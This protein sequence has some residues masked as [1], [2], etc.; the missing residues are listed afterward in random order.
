MAELYKTERGNKHTKWQIDHDK[1]PKQWLHPADRT[2]TIDTDN[3][4]V[5]PTPINIT[6]TE[7]SGNRV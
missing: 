5:D 2:I 1:P 7:A 3:T 4:Q 6:Q